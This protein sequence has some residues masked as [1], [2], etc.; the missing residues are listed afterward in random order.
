MTPELLR[1]RSGQ[2]DML[3]WEQ[4]E[5]LLKEAAAELDRQIEAKLRWQ[6]D[7]ARFQEE[8]VYWRN[9]C[10]KLHARVFRLEAQLRGDS[11][12]VD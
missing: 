8:M 12:E 6:G 4:V 11:D 9:R 3:T 7:S 2:A 1:R 10:A 5:A